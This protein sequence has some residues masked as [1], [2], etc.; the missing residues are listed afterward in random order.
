MLD[1]LRDPE[2]HMEY[3]RKYT[4]PSSIWE[5]LSYPTIHRYAASVTMAIVYGK[6]TPTRYTDPEVVAI[7]Q[8]M[9]RVVD[10]VHPG[11]YL[12]N[13]FPFL[14]YLPTPETR[15]LRRYHREE[16]DLYIRLLGVVRQQMVS[17]T[18][19]LRRVVN[20]KAYSTLGQ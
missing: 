1:L 4:Q 14:K 2:H 3:A 7:E 18:G 10:S 17:P 6:K 9:K 5:A 8:A 20:Q 16:M 19:I 15:L 11:V 12:V 13:R